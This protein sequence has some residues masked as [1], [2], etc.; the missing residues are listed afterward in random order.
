MYE[1]MGGSKTFYGGNV[2]GI[3]VDRFQFDLVERVARFEDV[4]RNLLFMQVVEEG[5][6][7]K[8]CWIEPG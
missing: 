1:G 5:L 8:E 6:E 7:W 3:T 4:K 2:K